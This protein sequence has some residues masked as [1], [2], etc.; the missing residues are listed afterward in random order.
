MPML[1]DESMAGVG[2]KRKRLMAPGQ[3]TSFIYNTP[4]TV[5][6]TQEKRIVNEI[7]PNAPIESGSPWQFDIEKEMDTFL[8][9]GSLSLN[10]VMK[11]VKA[12]G[13]P[14]SPDDVVAPVNLL[15]SSMWH[16]VQVKLNNATTNMNSADY[17]NYKTFLETLLSY[18]G[19]A[20]ETHL[21]TQLFYL[22]TPAKY[23]NFTHE[24]TNNIEPN[25][26]FKYRY[27]YTKES[28][29]FDVVCPLAT[30]I[31]RSSKYLVPGVTLSVRLTKADDKWL[32]TSDKA[33]RYKISISKMKLEYARIKLFDPD[34]TIDAI[35]RYP[36]SKT[37]MRRYPVG[38]GLKSITVNMENELGR[39]PK[40][41]YF[42]FVS[43]SAS[44]GEYSSNP[45]NFR[46]YNL[47]RH[48]LKPKGECTPNDGYD[49]SLSGTPGLK[50]KSL[51][52]LYKQVGVYRTD[53][54]CCV[55]H[56]GYTNG[57]FIIAYDLSPD[58]C[59]G[60]HLH[61]QRMGSLV[62]EFQWATSLPH[63]IHIY[64]HM[65]YDCEFVK[66]VGNLYFELDYI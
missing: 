18:E 50:N 29:E 3:C 16:S 10:V 23:E 44:E 39:I 65:V 56:D 64:A 48:R 49:F 47:I 1:V 21:R 34:F 38:A 62:A 19:D 57:Q 55:S 8:D 60:H 20:R 11:I 63:S 53:R 41:I 26:G 24:K 30:D 27:E 42:F 59:N 13:S 31:L 43:A 58:L 17:F 28:A 15:A 35:Q 51:A 40:Q 66:D 52:R 4:V 45:Y 5:E 2:A 36:F 9:M 61:I 22:D 37:E 33:E 12:D 32:L 14:C 46:H 25:A 54:G 7:G 6:G